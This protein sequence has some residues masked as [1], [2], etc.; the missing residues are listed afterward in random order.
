MTEI[1]LFRDI[2]RRF[3]CLTLQTTQEHF[4]ASRFRFRPPRFLSD[5]LFLSITN[6]VTMAQNNFSFI[7][8]TMILLD[9]SAVATDQNC[10]S[11][12]MSSFSV[13]TETVSNESTDQG[14]QDDKTHTRNMI[15]LNQNE[16]DE[17]EQVVRK[18][19]RE[20]RET[21]LKK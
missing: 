16:T 13:C 11:I 6:L 14:L 20:T 15:T 5:E 17:D 10:H 9:P 8:C 12:R 2:K 19:N 4:I 7:L 21:K 1:I 3:H 18:V